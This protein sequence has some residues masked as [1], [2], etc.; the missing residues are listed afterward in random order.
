MTVILDIKVVPNAGKQRIT[1]DKTGMLVCS[2]KSQAEGGKANEELIRF[3]SKKLSIPQNSISIVL[4]ATSRK[5][6][7]KIVTATSKEE[8]L[9]ALEAS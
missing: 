5:K 6:R 3:L 7:L 4:G 8:I 9:A 1:R 2:V